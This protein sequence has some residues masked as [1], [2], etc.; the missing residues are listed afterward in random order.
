MNITVTATPEPANT[1]PRIRIDVVDSDVSDPA[2]T[3]RPQRVAADGSQTAVRIPAA[4][5]LALG[6]DGAGGRVGFT[7][8]YEPV[9]GQTFTYTTTESPVSPSSAVTLTS[10][11]PWL[12]PPG[13]PDLAQPLDFR[14]GSFDETTFDVVGDVLY[15]LGRM[16]GVGSSDGTRKAAASE[17]AVLTKTPEELSALLALL[18]DA[19]TLLL[20]IPP[21]LGLDVASDYIQVGAVSVRRRS[22]IGSEPTR[23]VVMPYRVVSMPVGGVLSQR[24]FND[25]L[26]EAPDFASLRDVVFV[27]FAEMKAGK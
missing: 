25:L 7:Y 20:N 4:T 1:P 11:R 17:F 8:D 15:P 6:D 14:I 12:L 24:G 23:R 19:S 3:V 16:T 18:A 22:T 10:S 21:Q 2:D 5:S 13:K 26:L 9:F 27:S